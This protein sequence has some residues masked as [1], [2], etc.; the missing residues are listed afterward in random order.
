MQKGSIPF[1]RFKCPALQGFLGKGADLF[2]PISKP[3]RDI[4]RPMQHSPYIDMVLTL[5]VEQGMRLAL[6]AV[7]AQLRAAERS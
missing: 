1:A 3:F 5:Q 6:E 4:T 7:T 2:S